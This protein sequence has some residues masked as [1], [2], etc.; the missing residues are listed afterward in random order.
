M[1][2]GMPYFYRYH[3][4]K[5][6]SLTN[7][8]DPLRNYL[9]TIEQTCPHD[10]FFSGPRSSSLHFKLNFDVKCIESHEISKLARQAMID[11]NTRDAHSI[12]E[13]FLLQHDNKTVAVEIPLW[14]ENNE[15]ADYPKIFSSKEPLTGHIDILRVE[16]GKIWIWDYKPRA[17]YEKYATTQTYFYA[18]MLS[19]RT[20]IS[21]D[22]FRCGY[23][24]S[25][26]AFV[27]KP[28]ETAILRNQQLHKFIQ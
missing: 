6:Q 20:G 11:G 25:A 5:T 27:F 8:F 22:H 10:Y 1:N 21:L 24:D 28:L 26:Y 9:H 19:K 23:F 3:V 2:H 15:I 14:L 17:S 7:G 4:K 16:D 12:V 18:L 13:L